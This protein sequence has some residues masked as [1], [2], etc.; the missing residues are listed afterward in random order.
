MAKLPS[1]LPSSANITAIPSLWGW[2][3]STLPLSQAGAMVIVQVLSRWTFPPTYWVLPAR[4]LL[5]PCEA[6]SP[7]LFFSQKHWWSCKDQSRLISPPTSRMLPTWRLLLPCKFGSTRPFLS[8]EH[9]WPWNDQWQI[10][11]SPLLAATLVLWGVPN[12]STFQ[13]VLECAIQPPKKYYSQI[14]TS[15]YQVANF[16]ALSFITSIASSA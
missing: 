2:Q 1:N 3:H 15:K 9:C 14:T 11:S 6:G 13:E 5:L 8:Q 12:L 10:I 16:Q 4:W 7:Q